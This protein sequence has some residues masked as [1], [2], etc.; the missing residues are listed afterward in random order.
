MKEMQTMTLSSKRVLVT[1]A[2]GLIGTE[3]AEPLLEKGFEIYAITIDNENPDNGIH[4]IKG[5]LFDTEFI[6]KTID[7][8][9]PTHLL[10]MAWCTT[11]DYLK[12]DMNYQFLSAGLNLL[13][14]FK[15]NGGK[16]A[17]FVGTCFEYQF[18]DSPL[19]ETDAL[20]ANRTTYSFC[21]NK[22]HE[23]AD[24][25]CSQ[26]QIDFSYGRIFYVYGHNEA[27]TRLTGMVIDKLSKN[28]QVVIKS[29]SL[30]KD[31]MYAKDIA[32]AFVALLDSK[33]LGTVNICT[34]KAV[35]IKEFV[36]EIAHQMGKENLVVFQDEPSNQPPIIVG[37]NT[38]LIKEV[39]YIPK[40]TIK[41]AVNEILKG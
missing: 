28:E 22:L 1:G 31:Y 18:K 11:G 23:I 14:Y 20:D 37:D 15:D 19:K 21:K 34:G 29:A 35:S 41:Q 3:L 26:H 25:F 9:K 38:R 36:S 17:V 40:Y 24:Y 8:L 5:N 6:K 33:V 10:N 12:S 2:T 13:R 32:S 4:W 7:D 27:K 16:R 30:F 39:E